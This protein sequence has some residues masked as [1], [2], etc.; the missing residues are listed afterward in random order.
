MENNCMLHYIVCRI[1][2]PF[3]KQ[4][5]LH[6][7]R[8]S[9]LNPGST[10]SHFGVSVPLFGRPY[11]RKTIRPRSRC[12][13]MQIRIK[14][15]PYP[16]PSIY[17]RLWLGLLVFLLLFAFVIVQARSSG[18]ELLLL[19]RLLVYVKCILFFVKFN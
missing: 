4:L 14:L 11:G 9:R 8:W 12:I 7:A 2:G 10:I 19:V 1:A 16:F 17:M 6:V 18:L 13:D 3:R 15:Q 5:T